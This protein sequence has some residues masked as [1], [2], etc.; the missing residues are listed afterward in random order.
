VPTLFGYFYPMVFTSL[1]TWKCDGDYH[2]RLRLMIEQ[3]RGLTV[4]VL[5]CQEVFHAI[6]ASESTVDWLSNN[7]KLTSYYLPARRKIRKL[8]GQML[9][10]FSGL[11]FFTNLPVTQYQGFDLP[12]DPADGERTAQIL[13]TQ[14]N[15]RTI[16]FVNTHLSHLPG[17]DAL[18]IRQI[19]TILDR[20]HRDIHWDAVVLNGDFNTSPNSEVIAKVRRSPSLLTNAFS[21][22]SEPTHQ[23][24]KCLDYV[25]YS[26]KNG[27]R[28]TEQKQVLNRAKDGVYPSDHVGLYVKF[29]FD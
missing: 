21:E 20:I 18:R 22:S 16:A 15:N 27:L 17:G 4:D 10:S 3:L 12:S 13:I 24:G 7:L 28:V 19:N 29:D 8:D 5:A 23:N 14:P 1:N 6:H 2:R 11:C 25:F 26:P 9:D